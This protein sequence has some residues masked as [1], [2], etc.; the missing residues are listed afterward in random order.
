MLEDPRQKHIEISVDGIGILDNLVNRLTEC[1]GISAI[2]DYG[3][4]GTKEDTFR[5]FYKHKL[6]DPLIDPGKADLTADVDFSIIKKLFNDRAKI[7]GPVTQRD[8]LHQV[9]IEHRLKVR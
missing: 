3:H 7:F 4:N 1:G 5:A 9:G 2:I 6:H 8:F